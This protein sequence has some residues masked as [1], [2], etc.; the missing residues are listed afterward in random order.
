[1]ASDNEDSD[2]MLNYRKC[3]IEDVV[4]ANLLVHLAYHTR[5][6]PHS[7]PGPLLLVEK[8]GAIEGRLIVAELGVLQPNP[9]YLICFLV[10]VS[11][12]ST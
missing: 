12:E 6:E 11:A 1:M 2:H 3:I 4:M 9:S 7:Y 10:I 5:P 8:K